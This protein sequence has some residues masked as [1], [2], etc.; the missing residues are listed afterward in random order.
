MSTN[1]Q[2]TWPEFIEV[3]TGRP[4]WPWLERAVALHERPGKALDLGAGAGRDT[5]FLLEKGWTVDSV[6]SEP[7]SAHVLAKLPHQERLRHHI[8]R[9][10]EF[11]F[12]RYDL[13]NAQFTLPF[14][15]PSTFKTMFMRLKSSLLPGATLSCVFFGPHDEWNTADK[16]MSFHDEAQIR[17]LCS[18]LEILELAETEEDGQTALLTPKHWHVFRVLARCSV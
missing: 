4:P 13:V 2:D 9:F 5:L 18:G 6:D 11:E 12:G 14:N 17:E 7:R 1:L 10:D 16:N 3:T 8:S 15:P